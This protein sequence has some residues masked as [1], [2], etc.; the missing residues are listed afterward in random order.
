MF[1]TDTLQQKIETTDLKPFLAAEDTSVLIILAT[2]VNLVTGFVFQGHKC[3]WL[4]EWRRS[5]LVEIGPEGADGQLH[6]LPFLQSRTGRVPHSDAQ[7]T[8][9][10]LHVDE[11]LAG[12]RSLSTG[13]VILEYDA[14]GVV[15]F[16]LRHVELRSLTWDPTRCVH[17]HERWVWGEDGDIKGYQ[18]WEK[19]LLKVMHYNIAL[20]P[21]KVTNYVTWLLFM[22][23]NALCYFCITF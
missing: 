3:K 7:R 5:H 20:L 12:A 9:V 18:C 6:L 2:A 4:H 19:I 21:K 1:P 23:S 15:L 17:H 14:V 8:V 11:D 13:A 22:E 16:E 10:L